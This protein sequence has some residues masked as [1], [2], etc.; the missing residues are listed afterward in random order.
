[1]S[2]LFLKKK[3]PA[4]VEEGALVEIEKKKWRLRKKGKKNVLV[5]KEKLRFGPYMSS[6]ILMGR[7]HKKMFSIS[8]Y[9]V[10]HGSY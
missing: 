1:M 8:F 2:I 6:P 9:F 7:A 10:A 3:V 5:E 4:K